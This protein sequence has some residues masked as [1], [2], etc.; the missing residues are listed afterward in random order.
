[1]LRAL[2]I[3]KLMDGLPET[4]ITLFT[5]LIFGQLYEGL[6]MVVIVLAAFF[7]ILRIK[8]EIQQQYFN[9]LWRAIKSI[10]R[11]KNKYGSE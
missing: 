1:M 10:F 9:S 5:V 7:W 3:L 8:R 6:A 11:K 4:I 2:Y